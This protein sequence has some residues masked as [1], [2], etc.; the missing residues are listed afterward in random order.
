MISTFLLPV[1]LAGQ[2]APCCPTDMSQFAN[3]PKF[4][5]FHLPPVDPHFSASEGKT[6]SYKDADGQPTSGFFVPA[7]A[8]HKQAIVMVH[9]W[10]GLNDNIRKTAEEVQEKTGY[11]V[12]AVDLYEGKVATKPAEAGQFMQQVNAT[13]A[14]SVVKGAVQSL[15]SG[16]FDGF[17]AAKIGT[18]GFC[19]GGG[20]SF[21]TAVQGGKDVNACVIY[22]GMPDTSP[23]AL[24]A[25]K[26]P[27]LFQ[28]P[29]KDQWITEKVVDDF[30]TKM[31]ALKKSVVVYHYNADHAFSNPSNPRYEKS[32]ADL[33][34]SRTFVFWQRYLN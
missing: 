22:Y 17:K 29:K 8:G 33:A 21:Q 7:K 24:A 14:K 16:A 15:K 4:L 26:A 13:R 18:V 10:W 1:V 25:V 5:A 28:H 34:W 19:F 9:E 20:W 2:Q 27:V 30:S 23:E 6:V 32:I 3:D 31:H 11:A 12:L